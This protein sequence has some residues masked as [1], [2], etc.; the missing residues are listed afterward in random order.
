MKF[1]F[2]LPIMNIDPL[3]TYCAIFAFTIFSFAVKVTFYLLDLIDMA[4]AR[5]CYS[6]EALYHLSTDSQYLLADS[7]MISEIMGEIHQYDTGHQAHFDRYVLIDNAAQN[8]VCV[9]EW[10]VYANVWAILKCFANRE[11]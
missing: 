9:D 11:R 8:F 10:V 4:E 6:T 7:R 3:R 1:V 5:E 2:K